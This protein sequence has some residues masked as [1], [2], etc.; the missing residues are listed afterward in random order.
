ML[1]P[2]DSITTTGGY[3]GEVGGIRLYFYSS[4]GGAQIGFESPILSS[5]ANSGL[6]DLDSDWNKIEIIPYSNPPHGY[7]RH[8]YINEELKWSE[9]TDL[10]IPTSD[11]TNSLLLDYIV[12]SRYD[13]IVG[14]GS[15][16]IDDISV[17][18]IYN[19]D[20]PTSDGIITDNSILPIP[21]YRFPVYVGD[22]VGRK[23]SHGFVGI[24]FNVLDGSE[25]SFI[26]LD[27]PTPNYHG[28]GEE[29]N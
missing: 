23:N 1:N 19:T 5:D 26:M 12:G 9:D 24:D 3:I 29:I 25:S 17:S 20:F 18:F 7:L 27:K 4:D 10:G 6:F 2:N 28:T 8:Y 22:K 15:F 13:C 14:S 11:I 21:F 16:Y